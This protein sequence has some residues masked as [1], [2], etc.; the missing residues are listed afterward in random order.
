MYDQYHTFWRRV[1]AAI[2]DSFVLFPVGFVIGLA[3][4]IAIFAGAEGFVIAAIIAINV[5]SL[6]Y[7]IGMHGL[8]GATVGKKA[9]GI[10]VVDAVSQGKITWAQA[11][12]RDLLA[13]VTAVTSYGVLFIVSG[14][15]LE[16]DTFQQVNRIL[17]WIGAG[18]FIAELIT[19]MSNPRRRSLHDYLA[20]TVVIKTG[21]QQSAESHPDYITNPLAQPGYPQY[22]PPPTLK[23]PGG[24]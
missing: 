2:I 1:G 9:T 24:W 21:H 18:W 16:D 17:Q 14:A 19:M 3:M 22:P 4:A 8:Y 7:T 11:F 12:R 5:A 13:I 6:G 15:N 23:K 20:G 10:R